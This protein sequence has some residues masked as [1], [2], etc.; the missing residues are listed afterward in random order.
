MS[1]W[2]PPATL[3]EMRQVAL[4]GLEQ[5]RAEAEV[6]VIYP[7]NRFCTVCGSYGPDEPLC[8]HLAEP[9]PR[10]TTCLSLLLEDL[11]SATPADE[12]SFYALHAL[13]RALAR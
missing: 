8:V 4:D 2:A 5:L 9:E 3:E 11:Q 12:R 6:F 10:R 1:W 7:K 13:T